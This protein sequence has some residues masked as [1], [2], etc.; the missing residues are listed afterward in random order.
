MNNKFVW[1]DLQKYNRHFLV[2]EMLI[3]DNKKPIRCGWVII[4]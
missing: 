4:F 2:Q 1:K 3:T